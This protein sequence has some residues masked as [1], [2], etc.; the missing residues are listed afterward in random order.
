MFN[1][2]PF[3][4]LKKEDIANGIESIYSTAHELIAWNADNLVTRNMLDKLDYY[5]KILPNI[6]ALANPAIQHRHWSKLF[7]A[8]GQPYDEDTVFTLTQLRGYNIFS[9]MLYAYRIFFN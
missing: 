4:S 7:Y 5:K 1:T 6:L 3:V 9:C 8:V 2:T